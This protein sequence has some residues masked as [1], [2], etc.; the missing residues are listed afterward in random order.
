MKYIRLK[1]SIGINCVSRQMKLAELS[2]FKLSFMQVWMG[3]LK[4]LGLKKDCKSEYMEQNSS[5]QYFVPVEEN[6]LSQDDIEYHMQELA[7]IAE[8]PKNMRSEMYEDLD[9][10]MQDRS[11][12]KLEAVAMAEYA[13]EMQEY[14]DFEYWLDKNFDIDMFEGKNNV[15]FQSYY[16]YPL[17]PYLKEQY[18]GGEGFSYEEFIRV[19]IA[20]YGYTIE[21]CHEFLSTALKTDN[22]EEGF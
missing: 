17:S 12:N 10:K 5:E 3:I 18:G 2:P 11:F 6:S 9:M 21:K 8:A 16:F 20:E 22:I 14:W 19:V 13:E 1:V 7:R 4:I 15:D